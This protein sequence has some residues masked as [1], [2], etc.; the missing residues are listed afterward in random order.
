MF[1]NPKTHCT[2]CDSA[3]KSGYALGRNETIGRLA[4]ILYGRYQYVEQIRQESKDKSTRNTCETR[5]QEILDIANLIHE[6]R[7]EI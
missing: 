3:C 6:M 1:C 5:K 4:Q 7:D 2:T